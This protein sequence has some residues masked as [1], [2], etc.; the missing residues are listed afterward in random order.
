MAAFLPR[1]EV[2][3]PGF[4]GFLTRIVTILG[5]MADILAGKA[6]I[7]RRIVRWERRMVAIL[8]RMSSI[9][10]RM[11]RFLA[12]IVLLLPRIGSILARSRYILNGKTKKGGAPEVRLPRS[13]SGEGDYEVATGGGKVS[14]NLTPPAAP[15]SR[16]DRG[17]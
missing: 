3:L 12:R 13:W 2:I 8:V 14:V 10:D 16:S 9:L 15:S 17:G 7:L 4:R 6:R 11:T 5:R 1:I